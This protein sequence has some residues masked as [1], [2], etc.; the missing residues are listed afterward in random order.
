MAP[1]GFGLAPL[2]VEATLLVFLILLGTQEA[3]L[4]AVAREADSGTPN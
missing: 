1:E 3:W 2:R 4:V